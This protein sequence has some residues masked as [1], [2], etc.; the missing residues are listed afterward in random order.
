MM[1]LDREKKSALKRRLSHE[2]FEY[3]INFSYLAL[4]FGVIITYRRLILASYQIAYVNYGI[5]II[6]AAVL[7]KVIMLGDIFRLGRKLENRPLI[8][9]TLYK[10]FIFT[11]WVILFKVV[12]FA[13]GGLWHGHGLFGGILEL[14]EKDWHEILAN[15]LIVFSAFIPFFALKELRRVLGEGKLRALFFQS[16]QTST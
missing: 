5:V 4:F 8:L 6:E 3:L 12:E 10:T 9:V 11:L 16:G 15:V 14:F 2:M 13:I 1:I 7:G